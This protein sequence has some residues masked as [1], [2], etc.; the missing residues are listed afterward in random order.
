MVRVAGDCCAKSRAWRP[1][2]SSW[3]TSP[4]SPTPPWSTS[5]LAQVR[6]L[7]ACARSIACPHCGAVSSGGAVQVMWRRGCTAV[8]VSGGSI[9]SHVGLRRY[10]NLFTWLES[11]F[12]LSED[13]WVLRSPPTSTAA[14]SGAL[15]PRWRALGRPRTSSPTHTRTPFHRLTAI[16]VGTRPK[17]LPGR[18]GAGLQAASAR[19][20]CHT[21]RTIFYSFVGKLVYVDVCPKLSQSAGTLELAQVPGERSHAQA[22]LTLEDTLGGD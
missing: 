7:T 21:K 6:L 15:H 18:R 16:V 13:Q 12:A 5:S 14:A 22:H 9:Q 11:T 8:L 4:H 19:P 20:L 1:R 10:C 2:R 17:S 3:A